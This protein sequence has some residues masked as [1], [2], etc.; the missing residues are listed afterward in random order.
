MKILLIP[1]SLLVNLKMSYDDRIQ[2][3][4]I[5]SFKYKV[6]EINTNSCSLLKQPDIEIDVFSINTVIVGTGAAGYNAADTL[7]SL[8]QEDIAIVTEGINMGTSRNTGSDKQTYY[9]L[10]TS[11]DEPDSV[12]DMAKILFSGGCV[13]G[14][15]ARV[16]AALSTR[17]F[18]KLV[19]IGVPFPH[20]KFG[21]YK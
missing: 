9:K 4:L 17:A 11:G 19:D 2:F 21:E 8:G 13:H 12:W 1:I 15:I 14:D 10:T 20:N 16:E 18:F 5:N 6:T 7:Y 3:N